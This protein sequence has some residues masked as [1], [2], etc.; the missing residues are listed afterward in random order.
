[1]TCKALLLVPV[2]LLPHLASA[3]TQV[4]DPQSL[5]VE[6]QIMAYGQ[7][8]TSL[9]QQLVAIQQQQLAVL[10][11]LQAIEQSRLTAP[12]ASA[13]LAYANQWGAAQTQARTQATTPPGQ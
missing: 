4:V 5:A 2:L 12:V 13:A 3:Q 7:V 1:M 6:Q 9:L 11:N 10:N 8:Q